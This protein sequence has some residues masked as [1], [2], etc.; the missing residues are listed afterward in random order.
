MI[1]VLQVAGEREVDVV[2]SLVM[3]EIKAYAP[4]R[5]QLE[6]RHGE[7]HTVRRLIFPGYVF[8]ETEFTDKIYYK[9]RETNG[10]LKILGRP[11]P[12]SETEEKR[13]RPIF[14]AGVV[15][16]NKGHVKDGV[17]T[18]TEGLLKG[19]E[20]EIVSYSVRQKRCRLLCVINGRRHSFTV[21][22]EIEKL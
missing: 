15:G 9:L 4:I 11:T 14:E 3:K 22:A 8:A 2:L 7:W 19:R 16:I 5:E 13:L 17:L 18:I 10:V 20:S 21:S 12:L 1:Y 6:R